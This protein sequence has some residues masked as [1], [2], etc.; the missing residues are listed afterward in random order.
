MVNFQYEYSKYI[1]CIIK[2]L[3]SCVKW[4]RTE[5]QDSFTAEKDELVVRGLL[6]LQ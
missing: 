3:S 6:N 2:R 1:H 4:S 5:V